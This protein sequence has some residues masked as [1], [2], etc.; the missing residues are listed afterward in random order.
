MTIPAEEPLAASPGNEGGR[1]GAG[2]VP[3]HA[4]LPSAGEEEPAWPHPCARP[5]KARRM[6]SWEVPHA[7]PLGE[8][9]RPLR[10]HSVSLPSTSL[11]R[12][13]WSAWW[14]SDPE[15]AYAPRVLAR[16]AEVTRSRSQA[17]E[18]PR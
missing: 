5:R 12:P 16:S 15:Y 7:P 3:R 11:R 1:V 2:A 9:R 4:D 10:R 14:P 6:V 18:P 17:R 8:A 13:S